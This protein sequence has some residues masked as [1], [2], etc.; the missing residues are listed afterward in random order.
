MTV[1]YGYTSLSLQH[2]TRRSGTC[3]Q[4]YAL[5]RTQYSHYS[6]YFRYRQGFWCGNCVCLLAPL[7]RC[8][9]GFGTRTWG[10][11]SG[12]WRCTFVRYAHCAAHCHREGLVA[13]IGHHQSNFTILA[14]SIT[15]T[16]QCNRGS[17][18]YAATIKQTTVS[19]WGVFLYPGFMAPL[20]WLLY[21]SRV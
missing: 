15:A 10:F 1:K 3:G 17:D 20:L 7:F 4:F 9:V 8:I 2:Y 16:L 14:P 5:F 13:G 19:L 18:V 6:I 11:D 12:C 21:S